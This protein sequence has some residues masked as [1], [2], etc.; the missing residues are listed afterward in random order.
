MNVSN[1]G[2]QAPQT[3]EPGSVPVGAHATGLDTATNAVP[4]SP[5]G[6]R[7]RGR[8]SDERRRVVRRDRAVVQGRCDQHTGGAGLGQSPQVSGVAHTAGCIKPAL[9]KAAAIA[10]EPCQIRA[11][12]NADAVEPHQHHIAVPGIEVRFQAGRREQTTLMLVEGQHGGGADR[13]A[14]QFGVGQR[15]GADD[16]T[17]ARL[18][19]RLGERG[20]VADAGIDPERRLWQ[21]GSDG[22]DQ[23]A[24][25]AGASDR[26]QVGK[27]EP[28]GAKSRHQ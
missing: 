13:V 8:G 27:I 9:R 25:A 2:R 12:A 11:A 21:G 7:F 4:H 3:D 6:L 10:R 19:S 16:G 18:P 1:S 28:V 24:M 20:A 14:E 26:V 5:R 22:V 17:Q 23:G 15:L